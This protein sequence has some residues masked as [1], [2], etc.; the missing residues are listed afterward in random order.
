MWASLVAQLVKN[1]CLQCRKPRFN[2]W[3]RKIPWRRDRLPTLVFLGFPGNSDNKQSACNTG[4]PGSTPRLERSPEGG[5][6]NPLQYSGLENP[7]RQRSSA[8]YSP[9]GRKESDMTEQLSTAQHI[10]DGVIEKPPTGPYPLGK[11]ILTVLSF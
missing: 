7:H 11:Q 1:L 10:G 3:V 6:G 2:S 5:H 8:G 9:W 4:D